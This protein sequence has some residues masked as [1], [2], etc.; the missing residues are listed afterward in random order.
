MSKIKDQITIY[1][2]N[3]A[4]IAYAKDLKFHSKTKHIDR[5]CKYLHDVTQKVKFI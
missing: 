4:V 2:D 5:R 1:Y 3:Q